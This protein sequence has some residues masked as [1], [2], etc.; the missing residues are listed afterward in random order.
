VIA[1][2]LLMAKPNVTT[3]ESMT[4]KL[5]IHLDQNKCRKSLATELFELDE[6]GNADK[7]GDGAVPPRLEDN[8]WHAKTNCPEI[9]I[10]VIEGYEVGGDR[11]CTSSQLW[12]NLRKPPELP[13]L[14]E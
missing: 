7:I 14:T 12:R 13:E 8:A 9:A 3:G 10:E 4:G 2:I 1:Y 6:C 11:A 5:R